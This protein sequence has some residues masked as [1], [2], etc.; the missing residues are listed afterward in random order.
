MI[1]IVVG[2]ILA[3]AVVVWLLFG[4]DGDYLD[5]LDE[6]ELRLRRGSGEDDSE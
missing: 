1:P 2:A 4:D 5:D 6:F 3:V